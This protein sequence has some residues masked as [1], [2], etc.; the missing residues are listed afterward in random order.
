MHL[1]AV[2]RDC[3][4]IPLLLPQR[5]TEPERAGFSHKM[6][7]KRSA[8]CPKSSQSPH[9]SL[10]PAHQA[11]TTL[12]PPHSLREPPAMALVASRSFGCAAAARKGSQSR[13]IGVRAMITTFFKKNYTRHFQVCAQWPL[14]AAFA[15]F[16]CLGLLH[17]TE[18]SLIEACSM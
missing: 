7:Y 1:S 6:A 2:L 8:E 13:N 16:L 3:A 10:H 5:A 11:P 12:F 17:D 4:T 15:L 14:L 18:W 9:H